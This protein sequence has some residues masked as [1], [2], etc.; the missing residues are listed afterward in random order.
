M[1]GPGRQISKVLA[2]DMMGMNRGIPSWPFQR[3]ARRGHACVE[4][5][6]RVGQAGGTRKRIP[7]HS[8]FESLASRLKAG[9]ERALDAAS[10][11]AARAVD[12]SK[13]AIAETETDL[14][15]RLETFRQML[16]DQKAKLAMIGEDA[17]APLR[18]VEA[19]GHGLLVRDMV[20]HADQ[21]LDS[22]FD[23]VL[24]RDPPRGH[25]SARPVPRLDRR[26]A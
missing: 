14:G 6:L 22:N 11:A 8:Q 3:R 2:P 9:T 1:F 19:S 5:G 17:V 21:V 10:D 16:N 12:A 7:R 18:R 13:G 25:R 26:S 23:P 20:R 15:P 24:D 4:R